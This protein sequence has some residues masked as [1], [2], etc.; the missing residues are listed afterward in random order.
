MN[1]LVTKL[2][3]VASQIHNITYITHHVGKYSIDRDQQIV[4]N[5]YN[6]FIFVKNIAVVC[7]KE[8]STLA[9]C[10]I[11]AVYCTLCNDTCMRKS[12][13]STHYEF[14][15]FLRRHVFSGTVP[16]ASARALNLKI[17]YCIL[18]YP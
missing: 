18:L 13:C 2:V 14:Q 16:S 12:P 8:G 17:Q 3:S 5:H 11:A 9:R 1:A 6:L 7:L 10:L 4:S 15:A